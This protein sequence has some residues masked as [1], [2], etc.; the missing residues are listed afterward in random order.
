MC[1]YAYLYIKDDLL[2]NFS[3]TRVT[4][5]ASEAS[6]SRQLSAGYSVEATT[7]L[8]RPHPGW[9][10]RFSFFCSFHTYKPATAQL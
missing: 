7:F 2:Q 10:V 8:K 5:A 3:V 6:E 4:R 1:I 9:H